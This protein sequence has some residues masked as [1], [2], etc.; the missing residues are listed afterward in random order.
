M[1]I[2]PELLFHRN[3]TLG[4]SCPSCVPS[5]GSSLGS[6]GTWQCAAH[7]ST[8]APWAPLSWHSG[9]SSSAASPGHA[10]GSG[11]TPA[12]ACLSVASPGTQPA[13]LWKIFLFSR[14]DIGYDPEKRKQ[15]VYE[16]FSL[17][18]YTRY[19]LIFINCCFRQALLQ[20]MIFLNNNILSACFVDRSM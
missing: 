19:S 9:T 11:C 5:G 13:L 7:G 12:S 20:D 2:Q 3:Y 17:F 4:I 1:E 15:E 18:L 16:D 8:A 14:T 10:S 6:R